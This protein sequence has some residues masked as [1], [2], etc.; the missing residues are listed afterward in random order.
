MLEDGRWTGPVTDSHF[1]LDREGR[2]LAAVSDFENSGGTDLIL[3]H[4]PAF[5]RDGVSRLPTNLEGVKAAYIDTLD[6]AETVRRNTGVTVR[7]V[8]G[9]H[10]VTWAHQ[11]ESL[12]WDEASELHIG[13]VEMA[14]EMCSEGQA[15]AVGEVGRPHYPVSE[16]IWTGA[17]SL[18]VEVMG[19]ARQYGFPITLHVEGN[20]QTTYAELAELC[21]KAG[22]DRHKAVRHFAPG[23]VSESFTSGL[24]S[25][26]NMGRDSISSLRSSIEAHSLPATWTMETDYMDDSRRP[27]AVLGPKTIPK[28]TQAL[29]EALKASESEGGMGWEDEQVIDLLLNVHR[30]WPDSFYGES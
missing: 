23:D 26:V 15:V 3:V 16:E 14:F 12:G 13:A 24:S 6:M 10:P 22:L 25:S 9:P 18:L 2:F 29:V 5:D 30:I 21:D 4:K 17:N 20:G 27:G 1:H 7:V 11:I 19:M 8:L 28:R